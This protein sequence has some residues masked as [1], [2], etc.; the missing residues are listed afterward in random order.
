MSA[1]EKSL[2]LIVTV[3]LNLTVL[4]LLLRFLLQWVKADF[5]NPISQTVVKVTNPLLRPLRRI[6]PGYG[7]LDVAAL[8]L[9]LLA[10]I[11]A[12]VLLSLIYGTGLPHPLQLV[13]WAPLGLISFFLKFYFFAI[14]AMIILSWVA[15]GT[16]NPAVFLLY[17]L[18][19]P[20]MAP[21]RKLLPS[22]GGLD[23]SPILVF[24]AIQIAQ[25]FIH[26]AAQAVGLLPPLVIGF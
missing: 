23:L 7:G 26:D 10:E 1:T 24:V 13:L 5:Y 21:F 2:V 11:L 25:Y 9:L 6:V 18:V 19:E 22:M 16:Q 20:V 15:P 17:Q 8:V 14:L 12:I 4:A 3:V